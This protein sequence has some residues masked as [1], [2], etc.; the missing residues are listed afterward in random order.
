[1]VWTEAH[2]SRA[3]SGCRWARTVHIDATGPALRRPS[4]QAR[5]ADGPTGATVKDLVNED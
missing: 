2:R 4:R 1:M 3:A 5:S